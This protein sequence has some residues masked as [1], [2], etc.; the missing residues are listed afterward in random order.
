[1]TPEKKILLPLLQEFKS[2]GQSSVVTTW[3]GDSYLLL[4][5]APTQRGLQS[6]VRYWADSTKIL[7]MKLTPMS[8]KYV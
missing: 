7:Q 2:K 5:F 1:M 8:T 6:S 4:G 3:M